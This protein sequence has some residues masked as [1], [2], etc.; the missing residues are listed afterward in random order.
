M[1]LA[2][3]FD[4]GIDPSRLMHLVASPGFPS[5]ADLVTLPAFGLAYGLK[6]S[7]IVLR[8]DRAA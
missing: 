4:I 8:L 2:G 3:K 5:V 6:D 1:H 7:P